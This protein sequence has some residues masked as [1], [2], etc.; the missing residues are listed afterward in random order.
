M[1]QRGK[2][3]W[4]NESTLS[5]FSNRILDGEE[6]WDHNSKIRLLT[7]SLNIISHVSKYKKMSK[8]L[9]SCGVG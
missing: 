6:K 8:I 5:T 7:L 2:E 4:L 3:F 1:K 9:I